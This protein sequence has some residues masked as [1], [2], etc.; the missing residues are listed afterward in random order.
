MDFIKTEVMQYLTIIAGEEHLN[1][2]ILLI[3]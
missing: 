2:L 3:I 1:N